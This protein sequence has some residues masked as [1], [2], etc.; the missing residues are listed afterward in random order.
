MRYVSH[1]EEDTFAVAEGIAATL[2]GGEAI[3]LV[4]ELGAGKTTFTKGLARALGVER[5]VVSPTFTIVKEYRGKDLMLYHIDMYRL[6]DDSEL[7][8][9]GIDELFSSDS[10]VVI[11]WNRLG[12]NELPER[13]ITV[14]FTVSGE[15]ERI[16]EVKDEL[17]NH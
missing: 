12:E 13:V 4:G 17:H 14:N 16:L 9:L 8:E 5:T 2:R 10:V 7:C 1:S 11:E 15:N 3:I 6:E